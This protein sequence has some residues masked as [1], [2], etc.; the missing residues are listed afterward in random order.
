MNSKIYDQMIDRARNRCNRL[1]PGSGKK[2]EKWKLKQQKKGISNV[3]S[4]WFYSF[5][6]DV[7]QAKVS[8]VLYEFNSILLSL[9]AHVFYSEFKVNENGNIRELAV[10][11]TFE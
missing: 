2:H 8:I 5:A 6:H 11:I 9:Y 4:F 3:S 1:S 10:M 7:T